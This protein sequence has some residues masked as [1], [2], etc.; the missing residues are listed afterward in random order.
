MNTKT[1]KAVTTVETSA[2]I[3]AENIYASGSQFCDKTDLFSLSDLGTTIHLT[4]RK[5]GVSGGISETVVSIPK[6]LTALTWDSMLDVDVVRTFRGIEGTHRQSL[7]LTLGY[8]ISQALNGINESSYTNVKSVGELEEYGRALEAGHLT[9]AS[10]KASFR[11]FDMKEWL[12]ELEK[13]ETISAEQRAFWSKVR[14]ARRGL[15]ALTGFLNDI[16]LKQ[17]D[18]LK[19]S[20]WLKERLLNAGYVPSSQEAAPD[21]Y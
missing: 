13:D 14:E 10:Y 1:T 11:P 12:C 20:L 9:R 18:E 17:D 8:I 4:H 19:N 6:M 21:L 5:G 7:R 15:P 2:A 16:C 3:D